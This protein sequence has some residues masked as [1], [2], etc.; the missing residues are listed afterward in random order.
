MDEK[1]FARGRI[2]GTQLAAAAFVLS[3]V[4][5]LAMGG[6]IVF[7]VANKSNEGSETHAAVCA[8]TEDLEQRTDSARD[9]L[10]THP[11]GLPGIASASQLRESTH[12]QERTL[13]ALSAVSC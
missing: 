7:V 5:L 3:L 9:F 11:Q 13:E 4:L 10:R 8:L 6:V 1:R 2:K 12:N